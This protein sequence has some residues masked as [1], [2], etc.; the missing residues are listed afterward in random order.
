MVCLLLVILVG[1]A[2]NILAIY[3]I[4]NKESRT[5]LKDR[6]ILILCTECIQKIVT[7][8]QK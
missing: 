5:I 7:A 8:S 3:F 2:C 4:I 1:A 6:I